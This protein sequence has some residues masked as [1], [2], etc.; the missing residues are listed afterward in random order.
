MQDG[1]G[2]IRARLVNW[3]HWCNHDADIGP[4]GAVCISIESRHIPDL[5]DVW[6]EPEPV[7]PTPDVPDAE[8]M[9]SHIRELEFIQRYVLAVT[10]GGMPAVFRYRRIG[11][12]VMAKQLELAEVLLYEATKRRA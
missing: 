6:D 12:Q 1:I 11:E 2:K 7:Q 8:L 10:Y 4:K 9:E 5:G 3:G